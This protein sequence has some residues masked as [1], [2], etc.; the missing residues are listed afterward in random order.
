MG[1]G[2]YL[3]RGE[4]GSASWLLRYERNGRER[5]M[6]LGPKSVFTTKQARA[7]AR[8]AQQQLYDGIDP[9]RQGAKSAP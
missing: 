7:R 2:L 1:N 9:C 8:V 4:S 3:Q 6:G 5:W